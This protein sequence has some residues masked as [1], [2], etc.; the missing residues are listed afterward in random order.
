M[1]GKKRKQELSELFNH[2][3]PSHTISAP[4]RMINMKLDAIWE[5]MEEI[6]DMICFHHDAHQGE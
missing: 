5:R 6:E 2:V 4:L 1:I 3:F